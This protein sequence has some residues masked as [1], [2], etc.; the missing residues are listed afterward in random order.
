MELNKPTITSELLANL[1]KPNSQELLGEWDKATR[2]LLAIA[3][4][5]MAAELIQRRSTL[6]P[7]IHPDAAFQAIERARAIIHA[8]DPIEPHTLKVACQTLVHH[9]R[10]A[11]EREAAA[12]IIKELAA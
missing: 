6:A 11:S 10:N 7:V 5:E 8:P 1:A 9:S 12:Q 3:I 2:A 4:P